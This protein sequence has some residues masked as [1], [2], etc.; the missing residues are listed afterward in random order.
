MRA[1]DLAPRPLENPLIDPVQ[2]RDFAILVREE[3]LPIERRFA[4]PPAVAHGILEI[5]ME[6]RGIGEEFLGDAPDVDAGAAEIALF[7]HR[8]AR[9]QVRRPAARTHP[10]R[11]RAD[12]EKII[13]ILRHAFT[14]LHSCWASARVR[15]KG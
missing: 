4:G 7:G 12:G 14:P 3:R 13:V 10:A 2:A 6:V 1:E 5:L 11:A 8:H 9:A 15:T